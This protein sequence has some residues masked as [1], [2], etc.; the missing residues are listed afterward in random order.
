MAKDNKRTNAFG[1]DPKSFGD[2]R[3]KAGEE[4]T[5][6]DTHTHNH[7]HVYDAPEPEARERKDRRVQLLT[8]GSLVDR[9]DAYAKRRGVSRAE[10]FEAAVTAYLDKMEQ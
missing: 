3:R 9:M 10:V 6:A 8:Y 7:T 5:A 1:I 4:Q 2:S